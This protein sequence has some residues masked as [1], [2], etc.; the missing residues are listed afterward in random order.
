MSASRHA[1]T[2][3]AIP[4]SNNHFTEMCC[5]Y[6]G[7]LVFEARVSLSLRL[8]DLLGP[9][10]SESKEEDVKKKFKVQGVGCREY[11]S[12]SLSVHATTPSAIP[13]C[14]AAAGVLELKAQGPS[15]L[16]LKVLELK[17]QGPSR[18]CNERKEEKKGV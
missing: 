4:C 14:V 15:S 13:C 16:R 17:T 5:G 3:S 7:G 2:P 10:P 8:K 1:T 6:R 12:I 11:A 9:V 18:T